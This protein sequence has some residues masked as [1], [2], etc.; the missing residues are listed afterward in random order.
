MNYVRSANDRGKSDFGWLQSRH[1]FSFGSYHDPEHMGFSALR[2][3]NDD[4]VA[5][6]AGF[7][8]HGHRDMEIISYVL[9]GA[10]RHEDSNGNRYVV[11]AG[12]IQ[13]MSA[14]SGIVHSELNDSDADP[15]HFLQIWIEP[16]VRGTEPSYAQKPVAQTGQLTTLVSADGRDGSLTARQNMSMYLVALEAGEA[17]TL[18]PAEGKGYVHIVSGEMTVDGET[19]VQSDG[20][21]FV[22]PLSLSAR[23]ALKALYFDLPA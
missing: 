22:E 10:L 3:I 20:V 14:G 19:L 23:T 4:V 6:G 11:S 21:G 18:E 2:V 8:A 12:D 1:T 9:E 17:L 7:G 15:V 5:A 16:N 13:L